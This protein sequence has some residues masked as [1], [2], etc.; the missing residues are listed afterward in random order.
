MS[1]DPDAPT[2]PTYAKV[3]KRALKQAEYNTFIEVFSMKFDKSKC[4]YEDL[5]KHF[6]T[7]HDPT[8]KDAQGNDRGPQ[9]ASVIFC[10]TEEQKTIAEKVINDVADLLADRKIPRYKGFKIST[11]VWKANAFYK[12]HDSH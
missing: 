6:F 1:P 2:D 4:N 5:V 7:F 10:H 8:I 12:S 11:V 3:C 9:Y